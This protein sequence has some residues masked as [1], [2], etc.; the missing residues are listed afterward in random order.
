MQKNL[1]CPHF[2]VASTTLT[3]IGLK[4]V[5]SYSARFWKYPARLSSFMKEWQLGSARKNPAQLGSAQLANFQLGCDT[6]KYYSKCLLKNEKFK[7]KLSLSPHVWLMFWW[8][9]SKQSIKW[10][11]NVVRDENSVWIFSSIIGIYFSTFG[12]SQDILGFWAPSPFPQDVNL[13]EAMI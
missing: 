2:L 12:P 1:F 10:L 7:Q 9:R 11:E 13:I 3:S 5:S 8:K 6:N 4:K